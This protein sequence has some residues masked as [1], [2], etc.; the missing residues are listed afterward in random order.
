MSATARWPSLATL[1]V[2]SSAW[3]S[4]G[5]L[6]TH[7][8]LNDWQLEDA[9]AAAQALL[10]DDPGNPE[11]WFLAARVQH[12][13]GEHLSALSLVEAAA[14]EGVEEAADLQKLIAASARYAAHMSTLETDHF[15]IGY[16]NK[17]EIVAHYAAPVLEAAYANVGADLQLLPAERGQ[18]IAVEIYPDARGL[19]GATGLTIK[20]IQTS[21][22]IAVCKFHR[23]MITSPLATADGYAWADTLAHEFLHLV[24]SKK[25]RNSVPI[26]LHEGIAKFYESRWKGAAGMGLGAYSEK[27]LADAA[28]TGKFIS[29]REMHPSMAKLPSQKDAALAFA[30]VFTVIEYIRGKHG[31]DAIARVLDLAGRGQKIEAALKSVTGQSIAEL[32]RSWQAWIKKRPFKLQPDAKP[33]RIDLATSESAGTKERPLEAIAD[34]EAHDF[35]R[36]GELLQLRGHNHAA[37]VEYEKAYAMSGVR[38]VTLVNRLARAY[39]ALGRRPEAVSL[40]D[41][42]LVVHPEDGDAHLLAGRLRMATNELQ[43]A[44]RHFDEV[45]LQNPFNPEIYAAYAQL[46]EKDGKPREL[47]RMKRFFELARK[48]RPTRTYDLPP[49]AAGNARLSIITVP[50]GEVTIA[51]DRKLQ[52]PAF[53]TVLE[54]GTV[55]LAF[56]RPDG[57]LARETVKLAPGDIRTVLLK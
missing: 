35:S 15:R 43:S 27:L 30:Q 39:D 42:A 20:E 41:R 28:R 11:L 26:W 47:E 51:R 19:S 12:E 5:I 34:K 44:R 56:K 54:A 52:A 25:S 6:E 36:L 16:L 45:R 17:D 3:A 7:Q 22:T 32:E 55:E 40:L 9:Q 2:A 1:L 37:V 29:F 24:I 14:R 53:D 18:K 33:V 46:Y 31:P 48:P 23:L 50:W 38:Y 8:L 10:A 21:G 4:P 49:P 57:T 13:R